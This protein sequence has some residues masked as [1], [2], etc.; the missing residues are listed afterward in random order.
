MRDDSLI[1]PGGTL[2][3]RLTHRRFRDEKLS[4]LVLDSG[5]LV[6]ED[7]VSALQDS[8]HRVSR[9]SVHNDVAQ[10]VK[11]LLWAALEAKPDFIFTVNHLGFD[12]GGNLGGLLDEIGLPVAVWYVDYPSFVLSNAEAPCTELTS[13]F[14]WELDWIESIV[15]RG[16]QDVQYLPLATNPSVF[17]PRLGP[18]TYPVS[19][20][21]SSMQYA[22]KKWRKR[23][24]S[25]SHSVARRMAS[26]MLDGERILPDRVIHRFAPKL[27]GQR[28]ED[29]LALATWTATAQYRAEILRSVQGTELHIFG[30]DG[31]RSI[32]PDCA[33][34]GAIEYGPKLA[35]VY[36]KSTVSLNATSLQMATA[37]NQRVFDVPATGSFLLTDH[38]RD[39]E[40]LFTP[41]ED[42]ITY[43]TG[44]ELGALLDRYR[45]DDRA[46]EAVTLRAR[47][48]VLA[49][50]TYRHRMD[51]VI[52]HL[53]TR[54]G[55][56]GVAVRSGS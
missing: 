35:Q 8:G 32:L 29:L 52:G 26:A 33:F 1:T 11:E 10:L 43:R 16:Y 41:G 6:V 14:C 23:V 48:R 12:A 18:D 19:F 39:I 49:E 2:A 50:H 3:R 40:R 53:R 45:S 56:R 13:V 17:T 28:R 15:A 47:R 54:H 37:V 7:C 34:H 27:A 5:Y 36:R 44:D 20:A 22:R 30:D 9:V 42:V 24:P 25:T 55:N 21:G 31:W 46:R 51:H 4:V 38:Q